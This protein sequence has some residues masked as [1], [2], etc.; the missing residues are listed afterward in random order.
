MS[1]YGFTPYDP[2]APGG[3]NIKGGGHPALG[4]TRG[5]TFPIHIKGYDGQ[6]G[7]EDEEEWD[8]IDDFVDDIVKKKIAK[9][10][11]LIDSTIY[12]VD[13]L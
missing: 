3:I 6:T 10:T 13:I 4:K 12:S 5:Q 11:F 8:D 9:S 7:I 1:A 2:G